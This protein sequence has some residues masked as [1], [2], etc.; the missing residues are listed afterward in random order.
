MRIM[1]RAWLPVLVACTTLWSASLATAQSSSDASQ[2]PLAEKIVLIA[3]HWLERY[4]QLAPLPR[5]LL[6]PVAAEIA[7]LRRAPFALLIDAAPERALGLTLGRAQRVNL[8]ASVAN[9]LETPIDARGDLVLV[10]PSHAGEQQGLDVPPEPTRLLNVGSRRFVDPGIYGRRLGQTSKNGL[11]VHG[12]AL[13]DRFAWSENPY[14]LLD[15]LERLENKVPN[16]AMAVFSGTQLLVVPT[17]ADLDRLRDFLIAREGFA[18]PFLMDPTGDEDKDRLLDLA[19]TTGL[20][21]TLWLPVDFVEAPGSRFT[22]SAATELTVSE[23]QEWLDGISRS[24][25][26]IDVTY[27]PGV[28][29]LGP[30]S[31]ARAN[32]LLRGGM[33]PYTLMDDAVAALAEYD[34]D[35]GGTGAWLADSW[36]RIAIVV[37]DA[38][39]AADGSTARG[40]FMTSGQSMGFYGSLPRVDMR[41]ELGHT[42]LFYHAHYSQPLTADPTGPGTLWAMPWD[43]M[44]QGFGDQRSHPAA[45]YKVAAYW[46]D[47]WEWLDAT[48]GGT[49][50]IVSH[51]QGP[52]GFV[53]LLRITTGDERQYWVDMRRLWT[54][55]PRLNQGVQ[56]YFTNER[57][58]SWFGDEVYYVGPP[59]VGSPPLSPF[60]VGDELTD[61][62][63]GVRIRVDAVGTDPFMFGALYADVTVERL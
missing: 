7:K 41:H 51:D 27:F 56:I 17:V 30:G 37:S 42:F 12:V 52:S 29:R 10:S 49:F 3:N 14:R 63:R 54:E 62:A 59:G 4:S 57:P 53:R 58:W 2:V 22:R 16:D 1:T 15:P 60:R 11:P 6:E 26:S 48:A 28:L 50:R 32:D 55:V 40:A 38:L 23:A 24:R 45:V 46:I 61:V 20:Q 47:D 36:D 9:L 13:D 31:Q 39:V 8:P 34:R 43:F 5:K 25:A 21:R 33:F 44:G 35:N 18:G 19:W